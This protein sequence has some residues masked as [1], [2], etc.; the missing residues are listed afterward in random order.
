MH[1]A[2][3]LPGEEWHSLFW[4]W[5]RQKLAQS[6]FSSFTLFPFQQIW[7]CSH[8]LGYV[9]L[10]STIPRC[11]SSAQPP[12]FS[13]FNSICP[14]IIDSGGCQSTL[15]S[16]FPVSDESQVHTLSELAKNERKEKNKK[17]AFGNRR[18]KWIILF[19]WEK[20]FIFHNSWRHGSF[21]SWEIVVTS[22]SPPFPQLLLRQYSSHW[23][24]RGVT[25]FR[26]L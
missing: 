8:T 19:Q 2:T 11:N 20:C 17:T 15:A 7:T 10:H 12:I 1:I 3:L 25:L 16:F 23:I 9:L 14:V 13:L 26:G 5:R 22:P 24:S 4:F 21:H 6:K 18:R